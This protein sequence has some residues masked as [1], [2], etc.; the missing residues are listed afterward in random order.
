MDETL[1]IIAMVASIPAAVVA[2]TNTISFS[3]G[4]SGY[5][6]IKNNNPSNYSKLISK[7]HKNIKEKM[8][9]Y[10]ADQ[11]YFSLPGYALAKF[12]VDR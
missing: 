7:A 4:L 8:V 11:K 9:D 2:L 10:Y 6:E 5:S 12:I 1:E 3:A